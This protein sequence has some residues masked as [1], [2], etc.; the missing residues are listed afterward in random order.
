MNDAAWL[1][2]VGEFAALHARQG[3][4]VPAEILALLVLRGS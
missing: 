1:H 2:A 4:D 3:A